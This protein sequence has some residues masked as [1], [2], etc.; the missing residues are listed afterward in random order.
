MDDVAAP[1]NEAVWRAVFETGN[2]QLETLRRRN[3]RLPSAPRCHLCK[4][5]FGGLGGLY[6]R[7]RGNGRA[8]RS[9]NYCNDCDKFMDAYPGGAEVTMTMIFADVRGSTQ[10]AAKLS[11]TDFAAYM[12]RFFKVAR[13]HIIDTNGFVAEFRGDCV[14]GAYPPGFCGPGH[15]ALAVECARRMLEDFARREAGGPLP[16]GVGVHTGRVFVGTLGA[17]G[18]HA[19][20][21]VGIIGEAANLC[22]GLS[23]IAAAGEALVTEAAGAGLSGAERREVTVK[24]ASAPTSV[25]AL[26]AAS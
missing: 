12:Q 1:A 14:F 2:P 23:Q 3:A 17:P 10:T 25:W 26:R 16:V 13:Q 24:G 22:A 20:R 19:G 11:A 9:P 7:L 5:P 4:A 15:A 18:E 8:A 6:K 21:H